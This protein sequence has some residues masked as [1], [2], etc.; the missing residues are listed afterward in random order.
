MGRKLTL[1][2]RLSGVAV[3]NGLVMVTF[4]NQLRQ[5]GEDL[6]HAIIHGSLTRLRP[7]LMTALVAGFGFVPMFVPLGFGRRGKEEEAIKRLRSL[8]PALPGPERFPLGPKQKK[9]DESKPGDR[10]D[11]RAAVHV[12]AFEFQPF[13]RSR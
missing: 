3:L 1:A 11:A 12:S 10:A 2:E 6:N 13:W 7:V 9:R 4:I 8:F 5:E